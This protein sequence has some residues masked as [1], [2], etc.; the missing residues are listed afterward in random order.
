MNRLLVFI[1]LGFSCY[2]GQLANAMTL[3]VESEQENSARAEIQ[4]WPN[5][6]PAGSVVL[7]AER[8]AELK[9][10]EAADERGHLY[11]VDQPTLTAYP[12]PADQANGCSVVICPGGGYNILAWQHEGIDLAEWFNSIGVTAFVLK[13]RVPRRTPE[14]FH[15]EPMQ[16]VQRAIRVVR[17]QASDYG[18]DPQRIGVLGFSAGGHL[19]VMSGL[20]SETK[21]YEPVDAA[22]QQSAK[23]NFICPIYAAYLGENYADNKAELGSLVKVDSQA[24]PTFMAVT[25]DDNF[26]AA[27]SALLFA[28]LKEHDVVAE[29]HAYSSGGHGYGIKPTGKPVAEWN[30]QLGAWL[31]DQG[32][33]TK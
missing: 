1:V 17:S 20:Q 18:L 15:V 32:F 26:R 25:W 19:T 12:A 31:Q 21:C 33:L 5:G 16:D 3:Q 22:D 28:K 9:A 8:I 24:P 13:Y 10:K 27:Q 23:P 29:L 4:L 7:P 11:F 14:N 6:L 30:R 2:A